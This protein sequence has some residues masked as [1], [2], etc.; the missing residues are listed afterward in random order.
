MKDRIKA[1]RKKSGLNQTEFGNRIG[2]TQ[3]MLT[4]YETGRV[5]PPETVLKL[6][7]KEFSVSYIWLKTGEGS[8]EDVTGN[9]DTVDKLSEVYQ[10]LPERLKTLVDVLVDMD[11]DWYKTIDKAFAELEQRRNKKRDAE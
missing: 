9:R 3:A 5:V 11:R 6:I 2:A 1:I 8:M 10:S 4:S 7:C